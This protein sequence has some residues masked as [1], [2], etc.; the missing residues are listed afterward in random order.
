MNERPKIDGEDA[1][2]EAYATSLFLNVMVKALVQKGVLTGYEVAGLIDHALLQVEVLQGTEG[3]PQKVL[4]HARKSL[5]ALIPLF[6]EL[7]GNG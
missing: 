5:E 4:A 3:V 1:Y 6:S 2:G 7:D